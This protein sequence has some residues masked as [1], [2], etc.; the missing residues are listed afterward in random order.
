MCGII[1]YIGFRKASEVLLKALK[2]LEYRGYDSAGIAISNENGIEIKKG[3]GKVDDV[4]TDLS[5]IS[6]DGKIGVGHSRWATHGRVC[7][8]NAHPHSNCSKN[9]ALVH[10]GVIENYLELKEELLKKGHKFESETDTETVAHL[11]EENLKSMAAEKAFSESIKRLEGSYSIVAIIKGEKRLFAARRNSP[12]I[13]GIGENE[14]FLASDIPA[15]LPYTKK[16]IPIEEE[17]LVSVSDSEYKIMDFGGMQVN[18][19]VLEVDWDSTVAEKGGF[20]HFM[21]KE[22]Y[23]QRI[24]LKE[25]LSAKTEE[26]RKILDSAQNI[27]LIACGTSY[28]ASFVFATLLEK[29]LKKNAKAFIAS[30]YQFVANPSNE[31]VVIALTQS[32][33]TADTIQAVKFAKSKGAKLLSL[34]N[35]VG[36]S[37]TR[38]SDSIVY[39]NAGPEVSVAA[40]KT[41]SSQ[42]AVIY[43]LIYGNSYLSNIPEIISNSLSQ[44][45]KIKELAQKI[46][47]SKSIFFLGRGLSYPIA[48]EGALKLKEISYI[49]A[50]AYP[51]GELKHGPL[52]LIE[53]GVPVIA[54]APSDETKAKMLGNIKEVKARG[55]FVIALT[56]N[57]KLEKE[58]DAVIEIEK[59]RAEL[60]PFAMLPAL[61]LLAY[62]VSIFRGIDPDRPRNLAKSVTVE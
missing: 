30:D 17:M 29:E 43:K 21:L 60:Y 9:V 53:E 20:A 26:A 50:E 37:I 6:L 16:I 58:V 8:E 54:L 31:T 57:P 18:P 49:H 41:F 36:S 28:H 27:H 55:G 61:Q 2:T 38:L 34:T 51:A 56:D 39:L 13:L 19:K 4:A 12:L 7:N 10:N 40:T 32:G 44:E 59:T 33:E 24:S 5:F 11:I 35:V 45:Q 14:N 48:M 46:K 3:A 52:S 25:S 42:L 62:Y 15:V 22:I 23:D 1:G 47:D